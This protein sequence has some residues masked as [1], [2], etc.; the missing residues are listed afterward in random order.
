MWFN[1]KSSERFLI[2]FS[3]SLIYSVIASSTGCFLKE[4]INGK[5]S[6]VLS[7]IDISKCANLSTHLV[8]RA[9]FCQ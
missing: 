8:I 4:S 3:S 9:L 1:L 2:T 7:F 5:F 6:P